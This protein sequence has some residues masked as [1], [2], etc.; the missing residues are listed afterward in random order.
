MPNQFIGDYPAITTVDQTADLLPIVQGAEL[1][2]VTPVDLLGYTNYVA[3][4]AQSGTS[5]PSVIVGQNT[6]GSAMSWARNGVGQYNVSVSG[7][8]TLWIPFA[9]NYANGA[10]TQKVINGSGV[11][12]GSL[13]IYQDGTTLRLH[14]YDLTGA[15]IEYSTLLGNTIISLPE[16]RF[17]A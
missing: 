9:S 5:A 4:F 1:K 7:L 10:T 15:F 6:T 3:F 8:G 13:T 12:A 16:F 2:T 14:T 11:E 17:Y